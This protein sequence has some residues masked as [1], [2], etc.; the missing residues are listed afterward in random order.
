M[1]IKYIRQAEQ[2][3]AF[4]RL[5]NLK[6]SPYGMVTLNKCLGVLIASRLLRVCFLYQY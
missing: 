6:F 4:G 1:M 5:A 2:R 3:I